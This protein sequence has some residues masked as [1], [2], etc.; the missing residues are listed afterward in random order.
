[1][2]VENNCNEM[3][4]DVKIKDDKLKIDMGIKLSRMKDISKL[5][6]EYKWGD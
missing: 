3:V 2:K 4:E 5:Y 1:M 6:G